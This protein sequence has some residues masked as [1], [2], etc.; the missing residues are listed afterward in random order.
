[1][2]RCTVAAILLL[3]T[4]HG[5]GA[6]AVEPPSG[7]YRP[8]PDVSIDVD[9]SPHASLLSWCTDEPTMITLVYSRCGGICY[10]FLDE[11]RDKAAGVGEKPYRMLILS[12]D[13]RDTRASMD[14]MAETAGLHG[15]PRWT[16]GVIDPA[17]IATLAR[18]VGFTF[19]RDDRTGQLEHPPILIG[20]DRKGRIV[21]VVNKFDLTRQDMWQVYR[22]IQGEFISLNKDGTPTSVSCFTYDPR[23]GSVHLSWGMLVL[24]LPVGIGIVAV[25]GIFHGR[26]PDPKT[27]PDAPSSGGTAAHDPSHAPR[28]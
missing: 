7:L 13:P 28:R 24:Y 20:V 10:P 23:R 14:A 11:L 1:M 19:S 5:A 6:A 4:W 18:S 25:W 22:D 16:F 8:I 15:D 9:G 12:F 17:Q 3:L 27:P 2:K 21:R 26:R